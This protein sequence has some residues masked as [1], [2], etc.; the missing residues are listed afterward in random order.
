[1][2]HEG[3]LCAF[4]RRASLE[5][6]IGIPLLL[7]PDGIE[8]HHRK[9]PSQGLRGG[10]AAGLAQKHRRGRHEFRNFFGEPEHPEVPRPRFD[11]L[12]DVVLHFRI[13]AANDHRLKIAVEIQKLP[14]HRRRRTQAQRPPNHQK[15][16]PPRLQAVTSQNGIHIHR[17]CEIRL[18][19]NARHLDPVGRQA[20]RLHVDFVILLRDEI[21][22][23]RPRDPKRMEM[24]I[25][26]HHAEARVEFAI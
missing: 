18:H 12:N 11:E 15:S 17:H 19:R 9:P 14:H 26:N 8:N 4:H 22:I 16:R 20:K 21:P 3:D 6:H 25:R 1:M 10:H 7:P 23:E 13:A 5:E 24:K 2:G